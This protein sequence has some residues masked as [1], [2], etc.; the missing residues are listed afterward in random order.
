[1]IQTKEINTVVKGKIILIFNIIDA[2]MFPYLFT[3]I[4]VYLHLYLHLNL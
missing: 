4:Y 3:F 2:D 1:M